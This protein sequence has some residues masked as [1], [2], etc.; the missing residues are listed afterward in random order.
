M[1]GSLTRPISPYESGIWKM[2][3]SAN[4]SKGT[5]EL[6]GVW[7]S[8][9]M[10]ATSFPEA[11][12]RP[13]SCGTQTQV[14]ETGSAVT[15]RRSNAWPSYPAAG[16][17]SL[18]AGT[19][20]SASGIL[21]AAREVF[22]HFK[23]PTGGNGCFAVSHD[24]HRMFSAEG[25]RLRYWNLDTGK[26]IQELKYWERALSG[27]FTPDG[28]HAVWADWFGIL[29]LYR[30]LDIP[31][32]PVVPQRRSPNTKK[33]SG[34]ADDAA[35]Q[36]NRSK[37]PQGPGKVPAAIAEHK[38]AVPFKPDDATDHNN[39]G[40]ALRADGKLAEAIVEYET[41]IRLKPEFPDAHTGL[42][43]ALAAQNKLEDA[44]A[45]YK[46]AIRLDPA[47]AAPHHSLGLALRGQGKLEDGIAELKI[48]IRL[49][50]DD[51]RALNNL[52]WALALPAKRPRPDYDEALKHARKAVE[53]APD[54]FNLN[55]L[56]LA[57]YRTGR[58]AESLAAS[59]RSMALNNG[60]NAWDWFVRSLAHCQK[61]NKDEARN[62]FDKAVAATKANWPKDVEL[63]QFW[64]EAAELLGQPGPPPADSGQPAAPVPEKPR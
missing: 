32:L 7:L 51:A 40:K 12:T 17:R 29:H 52:A 47:A 61:G 59:E 24:G 21:K 4:T 13:P 30:L 36:T 11:T 50:P 9:A 14:R 31:E 62:W 42:G 10:A 35:S 27:A 41:A 5:R 56:T 28:R 45:E 3:T 26:M 20:Q 46:T 16:T 1:H 23:D 39:R 37:A 63:R 58:W 19:A 54:W 38:E 55:T 48:A 53:L 6:S 22:G 43:I 8:R 18:R 49:K 44:I 2:A 60:G 15:P 25:W 33:R 57:E 64:A 34:K